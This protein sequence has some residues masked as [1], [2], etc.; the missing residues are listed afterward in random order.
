MA[1]KI[2]DNCKTNVFKK[3]RKRIEE[4][5]D[6][7][8]QKATERRDALLEQLTEWERED[9][10]VIESLE[11]LKSS[12][13]E[14]EQ[15]YVALKFETARKSLKKNLDELTDQIRETENQVSDLSFV[16]ETNDFEWRISQLGV[17]CKNK[18][19]DIIIRDYNSIR[20]PLISFGKM[21]T[22]RGEFTDPRGILVDENNS[23]IFVTDNNNRIQV[24]SMDGKYLSEFGRNTLNW[25]WEIVLHDKFLYISDLATNLITKWSNDTF[26]FI[27][28]SKTNE[29]SIQG[30]LYNPAGLD[31][32]CGEVFVVECGNKRVSVFNLDLC[33][34][35]IMAVGMMNKSY[36]LRIRSN[37]IC[38]VEFKG[39]IKL[40]SKAD[41]LLRTID[42]CENF[43]RVFHF[44]FDSSLNFLI[45]DKQRNTLSILSPDGELLHS[46]CFTTLGVSKPFGI[47]VTSQGNLV[48]GFQ[49][50]NSAVVIF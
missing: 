8:I 33:F 24:W 32:D 29:G 5:F 15:L 12:K 41:Q 25:P 50:E 39:V 44:N 6:C 22:G 20:E 3:I 26:S 28:K 13:Q 11:E 9:G 18:K 35:R 46:I 23:R 10:P 36:C 49:T 38:I 31:V 1:T 42:K 17:L 27:A 43:S 47:D 45:T 30:Q 16:C 4:K 37:T 19:K 2:G 7:I 34:K 14:M 48:I 40:F 21:G